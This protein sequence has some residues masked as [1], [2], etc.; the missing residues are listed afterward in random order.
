MTNTLP[1]VYKLRDLDA[2]FV[3]ITKRS[4]DGHV[5][6]YKEVGDKLKRADGIKYLCPVCFWKNGGKVG[7]ESCLHWFTDKVADG[8]YP[9]PGRWNPVGT[10]I[11][12]VTF[13]PPGSYSVR[14]TGHWHGY[15]EHGTVR[16]DSVEKFYKKTPQPKKPSKR[17][18]R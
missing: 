6:Q 18:K 3:K 12:D 10:S 15:I 16:I 14:L 8:A 1:P 11:D 17:K 13:G 9:G 4:K 7:T 2:S 5:M